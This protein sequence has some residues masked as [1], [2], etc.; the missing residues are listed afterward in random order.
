V[1]IWVFSPTFKSV[2]SYIVAVSFIGWGNRGYPGKKSTD[3]SQVTD[4][5]NT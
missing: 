2:F 5:F 4:K 1:M 3:Q